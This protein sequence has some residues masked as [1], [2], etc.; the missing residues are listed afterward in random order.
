MTRPVSRAHA[1]F[2]A[3]AQTQK[4]TTKVSSTYNANSAII[5]TDLNQ[6]EGFFPLRFF[7]SS[8][9]AIAESTRRGKK[10]RTMNPL[11]ITLAL[12]CFG[13]LPRA[14]AVSPPPDGGYPN[15]NTA[16]GQNAL[17]SLTTG[18]FNTAVGFLSLRSNTTGQFNT[19][20]GAGTLLANTADQNTATGA[21]ALLSNT[22]GG[23]N[24]ANGAFAL[25]FNTTGCCNAAYGDEALFSNTTGFN[26]TAS[27]F[28]ALFNN[29]QGTQNTA[30]GAQALFSNTGGLGNTANGSNALFSN[31]TGP[32][33]TGIGESALRNNTEGGGNTAIGQ[34]ALTNNTTGFVNTAIG[35]DALLT[36]TGGTQNT[37]AGVS[38]LAFN[39]TGGFNTAIGAGTLPNNTT[40]GSNTALGVNAGAGVTTAND[41][42]CIGADVDGENVSNTCYIGNIFGVTSVGIGVLVNS[43]GKLGTTTSSRRFKDGIK[44]MDKVSETLYAL[45][46]VAFH[47]KKEI[48]PT[49]SQQLGL[50]AEEVEKVNP[51]LVVRDKEGKP[52]SVRYDQVNAML[53]NEFLKEHKKVEEQQAT[54]TELKSTVAQQQKGFESKLTK[55]E[56]QIEA[57]TAGLQKVSA[58]VEASKPAPQVVNNR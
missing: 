38:A 36:N 15:G 10:G 5:K 30:T 29:A 24:T 21:G 3:T 20:T 37:A 11:L 54:I 58:Q 9:P 50:V 39:T 28:K 17:F 2:S 1:L 13:L 12:L 7:A 6:A 22:T 16:E 42:I 35:D 47:Y 44:P 31:T 41:V 26:N 14:Q 32:G 27:G 51:D 34:F 23:S 46:P 55:Q 49:G 56:K 18:G 57:L 4:R 25:I 45:E 8:G 40:G 19:A 43:A 48:D 52:Y 33:N 53:L